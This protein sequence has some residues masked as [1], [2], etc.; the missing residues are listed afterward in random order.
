MMVFLSFLP[1][2]RFNQL[3]RLMSEEDNWKLYRQDLDR[4]L[5]TNTPCVPFLGLFL[6]QVVQ[7]ESYHKMREENNTGA[8]KNGRRRS[9]S[10]GAYRVHSCTEDNKV[11]KLTWRAS[12][13]SISAPT[14]P[15]GSDYEDNGAENFGSLAGIKHQFEDGNEGFVISNPAAIHS[16]KAALLLHMQ[17]NGLATSESSLDSKCSV[18]DCLR[19]RNVTTP[20]I[21]LAKSPDAFPISLIP[22]A[23]KASLDESALNFDAVDLGHIYPP[24]PRTNHKQTSFDEVDIVTDDTAD[25]GLHSLSHRSSSLP[26]SSSRSSLDGCPS[27]SDLD[28]V[29]FT[30]TKSRS[31]ESLLPTYTEVDQLRG[32]LHNTRSELS[33]LSASL[34]SL[35]SVFSNDEESSLN[36]NVT[37]LELSDYHSETCPV[38]TNEYD[39]CPLSSS[40]QSCKFLH[41]L[42]NVRGE[43]YKEQNESRVESSQLT[44]D[45]KSPTLEQQAHAY[46][47]VK[48]S[49]SYG[50]TATNV[51]LRRRKRAVGDKLPRHRKLPTDPAGLLRTYQ[52][53]SL[54][55]CP[56]V[57]SKSTLRT[58]LT[59]FTHNS[60]GQNYQLS[61]E[62][63]PA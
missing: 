17:Q 36:L 27:T 41:E 34:Q 25:S 45:L 20:Q 4:C 42:Q 23:P 16:E 3:T 57:D 61:Y 2:R 15:V 24:E 5:T 62:R 38:S 46:F 32:I 35:D 29:N 8:G 19:H 22:G 31:V 13:L 43:L 1:S 37:D 53:V 12:T 52:Q 40:V 7:Q 18:D 63:E 49:K 28:L 58:L 9:S 30:L 47:K 44:C 21:L 39:T 26:K 33:R 10:F 11:K 50:P 56:T 51:I 48:R 55:C 60:E 59:D 54:D 6:T 14:S